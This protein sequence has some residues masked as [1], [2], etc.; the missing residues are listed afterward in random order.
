MLEEGCLVWH[1]TPTLPYCITDVL[2]FLLVTA[3]FTSNFVAHKFCKSIKQFAGS[4]CIEKIT[5]PS[6]LERKFDMFSFF[7]GHM[8]PLNFSENLGYNQ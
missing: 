8:C 3:I 4:L 7:R 2:T 6:Y 1:V 5:F